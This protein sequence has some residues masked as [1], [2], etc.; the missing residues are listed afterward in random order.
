MT[1]ALTNGAFRGS[2][3]GT[4]ATL[5]TVLS[6]VWGIGIAS[7]A[8]AADLVLPDGPKTL[9]VHPGVEPDPA[10]KPGSG[11]PPGAD[12][13]TGVAGHTFEIK[14]VP[15]LK[16]EKT[17]DWNRAVD[18][19]PASA[20]RLV[21]GEPVA[22]TGV[23]AADN[24]VVFS[25]LQ[26]G[27]YL[28]TE[29]SA[30]A[31]AIRAVPFLVMLPLPNPTSAGDWLT[32]VHVYPKTASVE[33]KLGVRDADA[34]TCGDPVIWSALNVIPDVRELS[35]YRVQHVLAQGVELR[36][37][38][39]DTT[40][41]ITGQPA[42]TAGADYAVTE[43]EIDGRVALE[44]VFTEAGIAKLLVDTS[45]EVRISFASSVNAPGEYTN[46][47]RLFAGDAGVVTDTA[48]TKFGPLRI[49]VHEKGHPN[50]LIQGADFRLYI[51]ESDARASKRP[52]TFAD[53]A[54]L[55][56]SAD[57]LITVPCLRYSNFADGLD[58]EPGNKL[59]RDYFAKPVSY[60]AGWTGED[61]ILRGSVMSATDPETLRA[62]V[63]KATAVI[64]PVPGLSETG[65]K[66]AA[67]ALLGG[68]LVAVGAVV[69]V[70][71]RR[72]P[73]GS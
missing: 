59:Y 4:V 5:L 6:L 38:A 25:D 1:E 36:G 53:G 40:V 60:P 11:L 7:P 54:E 20:A 3:G 12:A 19:K 35:S 27:L 63:W 39:A 65:G 68:V 9:V 31:G 44:T 13:P 32:T 28:V 51:S 23:T 45:A 70:R 52:V 26:T 22:G 10:G 73:Q 71:R 61:V 43:T 56:T 55:R 2:R 47:V 49:L 48:T 8:N 58:R 64:P 50:H 18:M 14:R 17:V 33:T 16:L 69:V 67:A 30:P 15:G 57:G 42:L 37:T 41:E 29:T 24:S 46:E 66:I 72:E 21:A 62:V 34:V